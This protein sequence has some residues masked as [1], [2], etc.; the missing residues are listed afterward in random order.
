MIE[1]IPGKE[2]HPGKQGRE[3]IVASDEQL[4][5]IF[6]LAAQGKSLKII[7]MRCGISMSLLDAWL[8][9]AKARSNVADER[10]RESWEAGM[11]LHEE[12]LKNKLEDVIANDSH[13]MQVPSVMFMLK[14]KHKW[15]ERQQIEV[16]DNTAQRASTKIVTKDISPN[17]DSGE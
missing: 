12:Y 5:T 1:Q 7:A 8:G 10:V 13:K 3:R 17:E 2:A 4:A 14:C 6:Q 15:S 16:E 9:N 11:A